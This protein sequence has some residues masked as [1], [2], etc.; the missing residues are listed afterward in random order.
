[1]TSWW[2]PPV[3]YFSF[4]FILFLFSFITFDLDLQFNSNKIVKICKIINCQH[5]L[6][7]TIF[8]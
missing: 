1:M 8:V 4:S 5:K 6:L 7:E 3:R 2:V